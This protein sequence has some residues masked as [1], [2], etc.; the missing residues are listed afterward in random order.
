MTIQK[1]YRINGGSTQFRGVSPDL[2]VPSMLDHL[3]SGEQYMDYALPWDQVLP[4]PYRP[5]SGPM[6]DR[7]LAQQVG[8]NWLL[9]SPSFQKIREE[10]E[11]AKIRAQKTLVSVAAADMWQ[12][13]QV[14]AQVRKE[15]KA[16]GLLETPDG[17]NDN[18]SGPEKPRRSLKK[19]WRLIPM[20]NS[21][22]NCL[23]MRQSK[24]LP[25]VLPI[26]FFS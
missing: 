13:R 24:V 15:A 21:P 25:F 6:F 14:L 26:D 16:I 2:V 17:E 7:M 23:Q 9:R 22:W 19:T 10:S 11:K 3:E 4:V 5:W 12:E 18:D 8:G 20:C 1:F